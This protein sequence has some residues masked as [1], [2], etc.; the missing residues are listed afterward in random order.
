MI[1]GAESRP[2]YPSPHPPSMHSYCSAC[3][4]SSLVFPTGCDGDFSLV[5]QV[6]TPTKSPLQESYSPS[7]PSPFALLQPFHPTLLTVS[8]ERKGNFQVMNNVF[9]EV[10]S[11]ERKK[12]PCLVS[13]TY[14]RPRALHSTQNLPSEQSASLEYGD[15]ITFE[16]VAPGA[17][18]NVSLSLLDVADWLRKVEFAQWI[19]GRVVPCRSVPR[20]RFQK[21]CYDGNFEVDLLSD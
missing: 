1:A 18:E 8:F 5:D 11:L 6:P 21:R 7:L 17:I 4:T 16:G 12:T 15:L 10:Y 19:A 2:C 9:V 3:A 13:S 14:S 20:Q